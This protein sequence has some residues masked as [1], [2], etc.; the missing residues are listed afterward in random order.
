MEF[1]CSLTRTNRRGGM[2]NGNPHLHNRA[3]LNTIAAANWRSPGTWPNIVSQRWYVAFNKENKCIVRHQKCNESDATTN[4]NRF[5]I[6]TRRSHVIDSKVLNSKSV[7]IFFAPLVKKRTKQSIAP[8]RFEDQ[9][10]H[11]R[12]TNKQT[13]K[14]DQLVLLNN[15]HISTG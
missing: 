7:S 10:V 2:K 3:P 5:M 9:G 4:L 15:M 13:N 1:F 12:R 6:F 14:G 11:K 8:T